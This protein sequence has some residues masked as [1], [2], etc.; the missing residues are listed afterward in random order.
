MINLKSIAEIAALHK[1]FN[2][3]SLLTYA[4]GK[5]LSSHN[6][7]DSINGFASGLIEIGAKE[8]EIFGIF[9]YQNPDWIIADLGAITAKMVTVPI[10]TNIS[11]EHLFFQLED[12]KTKYLLIDNQEIAHLISTKYPEIKLITYGFKF[13]NEISFEDLLK[14]GLNHKKQF[15]FSSYKPVDLITIIYTSGSTGTPKGVEITNQNLL[16]QIQDTAKFFKIEKT[17]KALSFLPLAHVFERMVTMFY[18]TQNI[19]IYF[20]DDIKNASSFFKK[21]RPTLFTCV[22]RILEKIFIHI[23][24]E[25]EKLNAVNKIMAKAAFNLACKKELSLGLKHLIFD[26]LIYR[27]FRKIFGDKVRMIIC[28]GAS[29]SEDL[30]YFFHNI[31]IKVFCGYGLTET[32]PVIATNSPVNH[33]FG[34]VGKIFSSVEAM[35]AKD[36]ELLVKGQNVTRGYHNLPEESAKLKDDDGWMKTGDF[37]KIDE[38]GFLTIIGRKKELFKTSN[39]KYIS[40]IPTES[41]LIKEI[42]FLVGAMIIAENRKFTSALLFPDF[43]SLEKLKNSLGFKEDLQNFLRSDQLKNLIQ[44]K[45]N[46]INQHLSHWEQIAKFTIVTQ[47]ISISSGDITPSMKLKRKLLENKFASAIEEMYLEH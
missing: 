19:S 30:E 28:G 4:D 46:Q 23:R 22:P 13:E 36:G 41:T 32:S 16:S 12:S 27:K 39:G 42:G 3:P 47:E 24:E 17:D 20:V 6:F 37:A 34:T 10:F 15:D 21:I 35:I 8:R 26:L 33:K 2:N 44:N 7:V 31:G 45:I 43:A 25:I 1:D 38:E 18:L 14:L 9:I 29:L 11:L 40:P 5:M